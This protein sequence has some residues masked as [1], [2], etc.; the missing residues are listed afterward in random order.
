MDEKRFMELRKL[1]MKKRGK[2]ILLYTKLYLT[3]VLL[4]LGFI[5]C[6]FFTKGIIIGT[7]GI[8][9]YGFGV[10]AIV[11]IE[12]VKDESGKRRLFG[13]CSVLSGKD[14][15][16]CVNTNVYIAMGVVLKSMLV[17]G[18]AIGV[19]AGLMGLMGVA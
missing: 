3:T 12:C 17:L 16:K 18:L 1:K 10:F 7:V 14:Y 6:I 15:E 11:W 19:E 5:V 4:L 13:N 2:H 9:V 8:T